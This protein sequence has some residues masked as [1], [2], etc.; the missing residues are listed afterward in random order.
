MK[1]DLR[2][3]GG[4]GDLLLCVGEA[5]GEF[6]LPHFRTVL[7]GQAAIL[8][9]RSLGRR[10]SG[11][12][13][14]RQLERAVEADSE[15]IVQ[16]GA[17]YSQVIRGADLLLAHRSEVNAQGEHVR[18]SAAAGL[19]DGLRAREVRLGALDGLTRD[20][21]VFLRQRDAKVGSQHVQ[22]NVR[23]AATRV[24]A[25]QLTGEARRLNAAAGLPGIEQ[26]LLDHQPRLVVVQS[27]RAVQ[28][29]NGEISFAELVLG[30]QR[31]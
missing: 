14:R 30:E 29:A 6:G 15:R 17:G 7:S 22:D 26:H 11:F 3:V 8:F 31:A 28:R 21:Q 10:G 2:P 13:R 5:L 9:E 23:L 12:K 24:L 19:V 25:G 16:G 4:A 18:M 27:V 1:D 20:L